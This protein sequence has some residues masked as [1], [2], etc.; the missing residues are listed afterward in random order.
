M[1]S[2]G[3]VTKNLDA[4]ENYFEEY[5]PVKMQEFSFTDMNILFKIDLKIEAIY[6]YEIKK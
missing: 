3:D 4:T 6:D 1:F 2:L 5:F